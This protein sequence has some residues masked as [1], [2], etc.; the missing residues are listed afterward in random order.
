MK[1][2]N[3][4]KRHLKGLAHHLKPY[5]WVGQK[6]LSDNIFQELDSALDTHELVKIKLAADRDARDEM[7]KQLCQRSNAELIQRIG[8]MAVVFRR[9]KKHPKVPLPGK[10]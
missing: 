5:V 8:Q 3:E 6:G 7:I 4:Q 2:S 10:G 9:N 1:L